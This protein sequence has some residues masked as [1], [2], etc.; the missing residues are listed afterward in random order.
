MY[1]II[2]IIGLG[3]GVGSAWHGV[4]VWERAWICLAPFLM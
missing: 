4:L 2:I 1:C 3:D